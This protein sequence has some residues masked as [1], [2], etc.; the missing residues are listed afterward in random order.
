MPP[1]KKVDHINWHRLVG[2][3]SFQTGSENMKGVHILLLFLGIRSMCKRSILEVVYY[4]ND[5]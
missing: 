3:F 4:V 2:Q 5:T 1:W